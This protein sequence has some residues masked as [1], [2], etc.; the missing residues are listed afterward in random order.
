MKSESIGF[1]GVGNVGSN[2]ANNL[3]KSNNNVFVYDKNNQSYSRLK[4]LKNKPC[5]TLKELTEKSDIIITCLPSPKAVSKVLK[6]ILKYLTKKHI[7]IEMSTTDK[8]DMISLSKKVTSKGGKVLEDLSEMTISGSRLTKHKTISDK[9][10]FL[11]TKH[12]DYILCL[13]TNND[14]WKETK[15][16]Y[17]VVIDSKKL[18]YSDQDWD[19]LIGIRGKSKGKVTGWGCT[20]EGFNAK[21][22]R[23]MSDQLWTDISSSI[24]EEIHE[25]T[26]L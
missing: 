16:Y 6:T 23:S 20:S 3:L 11:K 1:I 26:I 4:N 22:Q 24:F 13:A 9:L 18:N 5:K 19:E 21:I 12:E 2:L 25:I 8:N 15:K 10:E 14:D 17:F 7:W